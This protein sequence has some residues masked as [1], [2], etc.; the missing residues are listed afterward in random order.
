MSFSAVAALIAGYEA[1]RPWLARLHG[2]GW[3]RWI[4]RHMAALALTSLLAGGASAAFA[5]YH[6]GHVQLY[7]V[8]ANMAA[9]PITATLA[10]PMGLAA[11]ALMPL[12]LERL[13]LAPMGW[14]VEAILWIGRT[15]SSWP[16]ATLPVPHLPGWGLAVFALGLAWL[17]LWRTRLR[18]LGIGALAAGLLSPLA[19]PPPDILVSPDAQLIGV[20]GTNL[21]VQPARGG[22]GFMLDA[23]RAYLEAG[24]PR[25]I[26]D[27]AACDVAACRVERGGATALILKL[28]AAIPDCTGA[29]VVISPEPL[30]GACRGVPSVD[31]FSTWRDGAHAIWL[32]AGEVHVV[33]DRDWRGERPWVPLRGQR[34]RPNLPMALPD[35]L[36][37]NP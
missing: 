17:C 9:V 2:A 21:L 29:A 15:V 37:P 1:M 18:L 12:G 5:S 32:R 28:H 19:A 27:G 34:A 33:S 31:R 6:F 8:V 11:L 36:P 23:W 16:A 25:P 24:P 14:G 13:A 22:S 4:A 30:R 20:G 26:E 3:G 35:T 7:F 10:M